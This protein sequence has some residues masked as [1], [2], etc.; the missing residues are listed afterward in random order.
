MNKLAERKE[1]GVDTGNPRNLPLVGS[2]QRYHTGNTEPGRA[3]AIEISQKELSI[4][5]FIWFTLN[6]WRIGKH[7]YTENITFKLKS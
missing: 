7:F 6:F 2:D 4:D 5:Y 3:I 1:L